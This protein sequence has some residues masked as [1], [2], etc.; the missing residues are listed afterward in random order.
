VEAMASGHSTGTL[1]MKVRSLK[2][3]YEHLTQLGL[4][5]VDPTRQIRE[6]KQG[7]RLPKKVLSES[8]AQ[9]MIEQADLTTPEG[10]RDRAALEVMYGSGIR[11]GGF[12]RLCIDDVN[13][14]AGTLKVAEKGNRSRVVPLTQPAAE[15]LRI[16]VQRVRPLLSSLAPQPCRA[17]FLNNQGRPM[18]HDTTA[19]LVKRCARLAGLQKPVSPHSLRH[20]FATAMVRRG[21]DVR[22]V[23]A[24]LGHAC[25][26]T[27]QVYVHLSGVEVQQGHKDGHPRYEV[28]E[29]LS[30]CIGSIR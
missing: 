28:L 14:E 21:A 26:S 24:M 17:L 16:Y 27:T 10:V 4:V 1:C 22:H 25:V 19:S 23:Q 2:R 6:P 13:F 9:G 5:L 3:F 18:T 11:V 30:P 15:F 8:E 20:G 12:M 7:R 29:D